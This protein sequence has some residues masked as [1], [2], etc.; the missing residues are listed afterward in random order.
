MLKNAFWIF[1]AAVLILLMFL[2]TFSRKQKL[3]EKNREYRAQ[4]QDLKKQIT[5]LSEEKRKLEEDPVY[6]ERVA[7]EKMGLVKD[8]EVIFRITP[9]PVDAEMV[10]E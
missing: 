10:H 8:G 6:R 5:T 4:I 9:A 7:R 2:P 1:A 3:I